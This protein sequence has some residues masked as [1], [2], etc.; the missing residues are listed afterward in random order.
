MNKM[1]HLMERSGGN[2]NLGFYDNSELRERGLYDL[3]ELR[4]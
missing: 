4:K 2:N 1:S 3:S